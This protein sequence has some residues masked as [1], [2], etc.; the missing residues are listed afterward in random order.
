MEPLAPKTNEK[1]K[2]Q[3]ELQ[4]NKIIVSCPKHDILAKSENDFLK[5]GAVFVEAGEAPCKWCKVTY[6]WP[7]VQAQVFE[8]E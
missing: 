3:I 7:E 4:K 1:K 2:A 5:D 8:K 6:T